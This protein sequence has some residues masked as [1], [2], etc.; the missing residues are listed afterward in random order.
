MKW[1]NLAFNADMVARQDIGPLIGF[2]DPGNLRG[3]RARELAGKLI[4]TFP[5]LEVRGESIYGN[6]MIRRFLKKIY[7][8]IPYFLYFQPP[9]ADWGVAFGLVCALVSDRAISE[10]RDGVHVAADP[11]AQQLVVGKLIESGLFAAENGDDWRRFLRE[12]EGFD[13]Y[14][15]EEALSVVADRLRRQRSGHRL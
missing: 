9:Q 8:E 2:V 7:T 6:V 4:V 13:E 12:F 14:L 15:K 3:K 10:D 11:Q 1:A 5:D